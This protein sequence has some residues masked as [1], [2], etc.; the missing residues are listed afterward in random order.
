M[1]FI[2]LMVYFASCSSFILPERPR[3]IHTLKPFST[4]SGDYKCCDKC[5][6]CGGDKI[7][8]Y[9]NVTIRKDTHER[10]QDFEYCVLNG[11]D[12]CI[13]HFYK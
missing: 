11:N 3:F 2:Y 9:N 5:K 13:A 8:P 10:I 12:G 6:C 4:D 1:K 7:H